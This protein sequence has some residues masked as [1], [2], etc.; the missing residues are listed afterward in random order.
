MS[1]SSLA[2]QVRGRQPAA[3]ERQTPEQQI[4][5]GINERLKR[6]EAVMPG[7]HVD[8]KRLAAS[9]MVQIERTPALARCSVESIVGA[10][11]EVARADLELGSVTGEAWLIPRGGQCQFQIGYRGILKLARRTPG[12]A[13]VVAR[14]V[15]ANDHFN[16][17][18]EPDVLEHKPASGDRGELT[19]AYCRWTYRD[20]GR[21][22][23]VIDRDEIE[24]RRKRGGNNSGSSPWVTD[25]AAMAAKSA[26]R[27]AAGAAGLPLTIE[28]ER[29][30]QAE[31]ATITM[32]ERPDGVL[33]VIEHEDRPALGPGDAD[34]ET[35]EVVRA[36]APPRTDEDATATDP[37]VVD[38]MAA[39]EESLAAAKADREASPPPPDTTHT[40]PIG[41]NAGKTVHKDLARL[42]VTD[43]ALQQAVI[44]RAS[45]GATWHAAELT[46]Q[47]LGGLEAIA[48]QCAADPR[49]FAEATANALRDGSGGGG[50]VLAGL[51]A[52]LAREEAS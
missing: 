15:F 27:A 19:H 16:Y 17:S 41:N 46:P 33:A 12:I 51:D 2:A 14:A 8:A 31:G 38:L 47:N 22:F 20:G 29:A 36:E 28:A 4:A 34:P 21:D 45:R 18:Y 11:L 13:S 26:V 3:T 42:G 10:C 37:E 25:Y 9:V 7:E 1:G 52:Y 30:I 23:V 48:G 35:G 5:K 24:R 44:L 43:K 6:I 49:R 39:L 50:D 32:Q 40:Q